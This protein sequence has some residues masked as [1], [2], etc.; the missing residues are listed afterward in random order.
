[1]DDG[2]I[3]NV[4]S[5]DKR[6]GYI[7]FIKFGNSRINRDLS[8]RLKIVGWPKGATLQFNA[9]CGDKHCNLKLLA[10]TYLTSIQLSN[11]SAFRRKR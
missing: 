7:K 5:L 4:K 8:D 9:S 3:L 2:W 10:V 11:H 6:S 1:M